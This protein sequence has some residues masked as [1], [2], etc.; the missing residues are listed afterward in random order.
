[1]DSLASDSRSPFSAP[2]LARRLGLFDATMIVMGGIIG[3]GIFM[4]PY[5]V[6]RQ[7]RTPFLIL[8]VWVAGGL[9]ALAGAFIYAELAARRPEVGGQYAYL[10]ESYHP[11]VAFVYGWGLLLVTQTGGMAAVAVTFARYF[12][13]LT[14]APLADGAVAALALA[15]LTAVNCL[16]V[17]AGGTVQN[18]LMV[19]KLLALAALIGCG[20][21]LAD[22]APA[23]GAT[24]AG[25]LLD[26]AP[27]LD[28]V[29][30]VGAAMVP[31]LFAY[32]GW[33]TACFVAGEVR[34]PRRTLPRALL[35]GV[36]GV[37][38]LYLAVNVVCLSVLGTAGLAA[39]VTPASDVMERALGE[40]GAR[41]IAAG[42][43]VSTLGFLSQSMLTA[44]RVYYA[45]AEDGL[46]F[47]RV[48]WL[49][50]RWRV[51][52]AAIALQGAW[53]IAIALSGR[54]EQIL[55]YVVAVDWIF[56]G[57]AATCVF[58]L[59]RRDRRG[60]GAASPGYAVPGH[61]VTTL[62]FI[63]ASWA[64]VANTAYKYPGE[65]AI[66]LGILLAALPVY[67]LWRW[68]ERRGRM[69]SAR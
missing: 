58:V 24:A 63:A 29:T 13:E 12:L 16:G 60:S 65:S 44:P 5:V 21:L 15:G 23:A 1:M 9:A 2:G 35:L 41:L 48:G 19:L 14:A 59:R 62:L 52:V 40:P 7:V 3:S 10:R 20:F 69:A 47:R 45:M 68:R 67:A 46:F 56:F 11:L 30:A 32:G 18:V 57:L 39:T 25:G 4:N 53:A 42:I 55:S 28:L 61:P 37:V 36:C 8:A 27:S 34:E 50:P 26:R 43:A 22:K 38:A 66:G 54:Y 31:V 64:I 49:H 6:A 51:P 17:R 33:Q